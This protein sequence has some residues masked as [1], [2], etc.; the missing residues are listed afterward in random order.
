M[1]ELGFII[2]EE[3]KGFASS[4]QGLVRRGGRPV[5]IYDNIVEIFDPD[6]EHGAELSGPVSLLLEE[7]CRKVRSS[8]F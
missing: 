6:D 2:E 1:V 7:R 5:F 4:S 3:R 8:T